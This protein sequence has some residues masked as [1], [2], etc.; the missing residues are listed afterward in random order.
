MRLHELM[1]WIWTMPFYAAGRVAGECV[2]AMRLARAAVVLGFRDGE[3][4]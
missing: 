4:L 2:K 1:K 3:K